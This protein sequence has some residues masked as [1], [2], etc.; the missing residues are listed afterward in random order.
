M[1]DS[2][3]A[4]ALELLTI[5]L[6]QTHP[7]PAA[8]KT[9]F[10]KLRADVS[11]LVIPFEPHLDQAGYQALDRHCERLLKQLDVEIRGR[12]GRESPAR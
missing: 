8:L 3:H 7:N 4:V 6:I 5:A 2:Q 10:M 1:T 9:A 11:A 12:A